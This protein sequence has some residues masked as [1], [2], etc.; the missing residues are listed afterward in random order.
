[1]LKQKEEVEKSYENTK[2]LSNIGREITAVLSAEEILK[3]VYENVNKLMDASAFGI[4][5]FNAKKKQLEFSGFMEKGEKL[6][7]YFIEDNEE[8]RPAILCF[9]KQQ[10][11]FIN[12]FQKEYNNYFPNSKIPEPKEGEQPHSMIY[13]PL[14][15]ADKHIGV[16]TVQ[17][18][19]E[20]SYTE[21][22]LNILTVILL[23][24]AGGNG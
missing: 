11:I 23:P 4:G 20:N 19:K 2:L 7:F 21:Y 8:T 6:P 18:F 9:K 15:I 1:V 12:D 3:K 10:E 14:S 13:L 22:H 5:I 17:S 16:I 24:A